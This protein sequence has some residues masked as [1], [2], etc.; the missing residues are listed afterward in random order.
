MRKTRIVTV[1]VGVTALVFA[2]PALSMPSTLTI[3]HEQTSAGVLD[4]R[5]RDRIGAIGTIIAAI[6]TDMDIGPIIGRTTGLMRITGLPVLRG[7]SVLLLW[8]GPVSVWG[9][10][11][12]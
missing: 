5:Y 10:R 8:A 2:K 11:S 6:H 9:S 7:L 4:V 12:K 1:A 3:E